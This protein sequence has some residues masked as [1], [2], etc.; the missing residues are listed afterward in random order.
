MAIVCWL[1][2]RRCNSLSAVWGFGLIQAI[3]HINHFC[4]WTHLFSLFSLP[5][6]VRSVGKRLSFSFNNT[7]WCTCL[8]AIGFLPLTLI[9]PHSLFFLLLLSVF[10][11]LPPGIAKISAY[12]DHLWSMFWSFF[13][14][15]STRGDNFMWQAATFRDKCAC[16]CGCSFS[17]AFFATDRGNKRFIYTHTHTCTHSY[18]PGVFILSWFL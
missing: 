14:F 11:G 7:N 9:L 16:F 13:P 6:H 1:W 12:F 17:W 3:R 15:C 8:C 4:A 2:W 10:S 5:P 18:R